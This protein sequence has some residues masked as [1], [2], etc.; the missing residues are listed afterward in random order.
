ML[1]GTPKRA[2]KPF[3]ASGKKKQSSIFDFFGKKNTPKKKPVVSPPNSVKGEDK[4]EVSHEEISRCEPVKSE[5]FTQK[6]G[7]QGTDLKPLDNPLE[8]PLPSSQDS[9]ST[10]T[11]RRKVVYTEL[12]EDEEDEV[13]SKKR[14]RTIIESDS[15][16][17]FK[18]DEDDDADDLEDDEPSGSAIKELEG[19][20]VEMDEVDE[21]DKL[22]EAHEA[23]KKPTGKVS[24]AQKY[25]ASSS[26]TTTPAK[27]NKK[28]KSSSADTPGKKFKK[29]NDERYQWLVDVRDA[30]KRAPNDP[31][32][33]PRTLYVPSSAWAKFTP[34]ETQYW[35]IKSKM[36]DSVVFFKKGKFYELY[37]K[38]ALLGHSLFDLKLAGT[39]RAN[40]QLAG[41]PEMSFDYWASEFIKKGYKV[42]RVDQKE[43]LLAKQMG[44]RASGKKE[45]KII[46]RELKCV[47][48]GGT[49]TQEGMLLDDMATYCISIHQ[50]LKKD[51]SSTFGI[52]VIDTAVGDIRLLQFEDDPECTLLETLV[53][54]VRPKEVIVAKGNLL[55]LAAKM[56]RF[57]CSGNAL[58]NF[59]C[60]VDEFWDADRTLEEMAHAGYFAAKDLDDRSNWPPVLVDFIEKEEAFSAFGGLLS[61]LRLLKLDKEL[62]SIGNISEYSLYSSANL[63]VLDGQTLQNLEIFANLTNGSDK[64]TLFKLLNRAVTPFGKRQLRH[65][66]CHPL[67]DI[68]AINARLDA[69]DAL[70][71]DGLLLDT[72]RSALSKLPDLERMLARI[73]AGSLRVRD[74]ARVI[75]A[76]V[77]IHK[78]VS[79]MDASSLA[80]VL[81]TFFESVPKELGDMVKEWETAIDYS[82]A[83]N[84]VLVPEK[85]VEPDFDSS[86][87][88]QKKLE[89]QLNTLLREYKKT[90]KT[91]EICFRDSGKEIY[92]V[93]VP[94]KAVKLIP[95]SWTMMGLTLKNKRFW[96]PEV[97][98]LVQELNEA[99]ETHKQVAAALKL[100]IYARFS[101]KYN[102]WFATVQAIANIDCIMSL[103]LV[104]EGL[105]SPSCRPVL[106]SGSRARVEFE[107]LRH[108]CF[109]GGTTSAEFVPN[110]ISLGSDFR[111]G[112]LTG[113][114]AAGKLTVL[115]MTC[116][117]VIMAQMGCY[118]P[119]SKA[120]VCPIDRIMT[121]L[122]ANDNLIQG[123][124][125]FFV[126]MA[127]TKRILESA[128]PK[129]LL[130]LDELGRGGSSS[131][132]FAIAEAV[133]HHLATHVQSVGFFATHYASLGMP[134]ANHP[135]VHPMRMATI[136]EAGL[137]R[138]TFLYR[139]ENGAA[140]GSFGM[141]VAAMCGVE[142]RIIVE[143]EKAARELEHTSVLKKKNQKGGLGEQGVPLGLQSDF[144]WLVRGGLGR[145]S[146]QTAE[147]GAVWDEN[148][149]K[150]TLRGVLGMVG[151]L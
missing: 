76:F 144:S 147:G 63:L 3:E 105:G 107:E 106:E 149:A 118:V 148:M 96:P 80:G 38:D 135:A 43:S 139:L 10:P 9:S 88:C 132:G 119:A 69:V 58:W 29:Q 87:A 100:R 6:L 104:L 50:I 37:E 13:V 54:Q 137:R 143:A 122:G 125:T 103:A 142:E 66:M 20:D 102:L 70:L 121:R 111:I 115:R 60:P 53:S 79:S 55:P 26:Y 90:Y 120:V 126:E 40:M 33:D 128:T 15:E 85:G 68:S 74:F 114:N 19:S 23:Q 51:G 110:D 127:E 65:W 1:T 2:K 73:H 129:S 64:G 21:L 44:A 35:E 42:A 49:L 52:A 141:N 28:Q 62:I 5:S 145:G 123:K 32:Y 134:F 7:S 72:L 130:V 86:V 89:D 82:E 99:R 46:E 16:D 30:Q 57:N 41:I 109:V 98:D 112:L 91:Q 138:V 131:D 71:H 67:F 81:R 47:L 31:D 150:E 61:Y 75:D 17:E 22:L 116:V 12:S 117:G 48:T 124:S 25:D 14:K 108:P 56:V 94:N 8:T 34:F 18:P 93:E 136:A 133:L 95:K 113:A 146:G 24:L 140:A 78:L 36:W 59:L 45:P 83:A 92:L 11:R 39:G 77:V 97:R 27:Q 4:L 151:G 101:E 84:D